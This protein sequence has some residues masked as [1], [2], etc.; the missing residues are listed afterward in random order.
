MNS[1]IHIIYIAHAIISDTITDWQMNNVNL[2]VSEFPH[3]SELFGR[4]VRKKI[5]ECESSGE[6]RARVQELH[7]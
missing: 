6:N 5:K 3:P 1:L 7:L 4:K 2:P